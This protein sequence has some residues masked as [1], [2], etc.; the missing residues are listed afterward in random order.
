MLII[1]INQVGIAQT[2]KENADL[3]DWTNVEQV[4]TGGFN[5]PP[6]N[7]TRPQL[8][9]SGSGEIGPNIKEEAEDIF[10]LVKTGDDGDDG[11]DNGSEPS[12]NQVE[13]GDKGEYG[14]KRF[15]GEFGV[16]NPRNVII[17]VFF[18]RNLATNPYIVSINSLRRFILVQGRNVDV[19]VNILDGLDTWIFW[20]ICM[21]IY[22]YIC[23]M[24][25]VYIYLKIRSLTHRNQLFIPIRPASMGPSIF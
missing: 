9:T 1:E 21:C 19:V 14:D 7:K 22:I 17:N 25:P 15:G 2:D 13:D 8:N 23:D 16:V 5:S 4:M 24:S 6:L 11:D 3:D 18:G 10:Q 12:G 20:G